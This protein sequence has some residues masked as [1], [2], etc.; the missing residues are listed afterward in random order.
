MKPATVLL[1]ALLCA[2]AP[3]EISP[4]SGETGDT[5][6]DVCLPSTIECG[7]ELN[8][9][10]IPDE[11]VDKTNGDAFPDLRPHSDLTGIVCTDFDVGSEPG[12]ASELRKVPY[13][14]YDAP[15]DAVPRACGIGC[16]TDED[17]WGDMTMTANKFP[18][19]VLSNRASGRGLCAFPCNMDEDCPGTMVCDDGWCEGNW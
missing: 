8:L 17:C 2:C 11:C 10:L 15:G 6:G 13:A 1:F 9:W 18:H 14:Q 12:L 19:C 4:D 3:G 5:C 16:C 7:L